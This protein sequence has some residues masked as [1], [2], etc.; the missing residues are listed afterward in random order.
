MIN[1]APASKAPSGHLN[2]HLEML[3]LGP[4]ASVDEINM[5]YLTL[6]KRFPQ[7]PTEEDEARMVELRRA[8]DALRRAYAPLKAAPSSRPGGEAMNNKAPASKAPASKGPGGHL[9]R[10]LEMLGLGPGASVDEVNTAYFTLVKRFPQNPTEEDE[11][12][13]EELRRAYDTLRHAYAPEKKRVRR[14]LLDRRYLAP[15]GG[16]LAAFMLI[17]LLAMNYGTIRTKLIH[18]EPGAILRLKDKAE[19]Y[20]E[21]VGFESQHRFDRGNPGPA[22]QIRKNDGSTVWVGERLVVNGM[23][24]T[25]AR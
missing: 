5:A 12:R 18:F 1:K 24:P 6:V 23:A 19:P 11:A 16:A 8:Y 25:Q 9:N 3:G 15:I 14:S 20:G 7:N 17:G 13:M 21:V 2:R 4:G 22:Y 10:L